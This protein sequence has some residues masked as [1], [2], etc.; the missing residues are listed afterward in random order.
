MSLK[1]LKKL[2][3]EKGLKGFSNKKKADLIKLLE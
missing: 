1:E 3:K 2:C